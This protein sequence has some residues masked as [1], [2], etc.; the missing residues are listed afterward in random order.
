MNWEKY[1]EKLATGESIQF[2]PRGNFMSPI[3]DS[4]DL[5]TVVPFSED[6]LKKGDVVFCRVK[7]TYYVHQIQ[8]ITR[9]MSGCRF[10][11]GNAKNHTN[12]TIGFQSIF[13]KVTK[14]ER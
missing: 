3:I 14:V 10:Q 1:K 6:D 9:H 12:G 4:G 8:S 13:G 2:R 7:G 11:I 5:V